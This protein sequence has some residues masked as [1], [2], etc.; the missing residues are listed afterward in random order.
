MKMK[1]RMKARKVKRMKR[2]RKKM[3]MTKRRRRSQ[4]NSHKSPKNQS[5]YPLNLL[6]RRRSLKLTRSLKIRK[7]HRKRQLP[8]NLKRN[9]MKMIREQK[10]WR[11]TWITT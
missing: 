1:R 7:L 3:V 9:L 11:R 8:K 4:R 10:V 2:R 5:I 6:Q